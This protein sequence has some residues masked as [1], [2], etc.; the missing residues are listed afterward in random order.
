MFTDPVSAR[1]TGSPALIAICIPTF[2]RNELLGE[3]LAALA[4]VRIPAG[5]RAR[6]IVADNDAEGGARRICEERAAALPW[7]LT[8]V[9]EPK[10]G[11]AAVRNRLLREAADAGAEW[12][13]FID[14]DEHPDPCW[15]ERHI[16]TLARFGAAVSSGPVV[17][18]QTPGSAERLRRTGRETGSTPRYVACNNVVFSSRL[19]TAQH[20]E[21]DPQFDFMGGEDFDFFDASKRAGNAHVWS[22][23]AIVY[24]S[25]PPERATLRYLFVRHFSGAINSVARYRKER[26]AAGAWLH[27]GIKAAGKSIGACAALLTWPVRGRAALNDFVKRAANAAGYLS[28]LAHVRFERYR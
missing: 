19:F 10:R 7:P 16:D 1:K 11:L 26:S 9:V 18:P 3:C 4:A 5:C 24:E 20:L 27:F 15:L 17:Q 28:A 22:A 13:A 14:D 25:V 21:F 6:Q 8:Y 12:I 2:R 23:E